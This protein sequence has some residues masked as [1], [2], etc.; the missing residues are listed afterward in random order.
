MPFVLDA[1]VA[2]SWA[3]EDEI[4]PYTDYVLGTLDSD[5]ARAPAIWPLEITNVV[6]GS[7]RHGRL[8][9]AD[10]AR[11]ISLIRSLPIRT[12]DVALERAVG[13]VLNLARAQTLTTYDAS[14]LELAQREAL[15]LATQDDR[16]RAAAQ[17]LG[18]SLLEL[19]ED[20]TFDED[21]VSE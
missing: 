10:T 2:V 3:F 6:L 16:L 17:R 8:Q 5:V 20:A 11:F 15:P 21:S 4:S 18:V 13:A 9:P 12:D 7:E 14:Y 19:P 1:S